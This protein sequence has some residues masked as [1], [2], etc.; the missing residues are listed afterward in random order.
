MNTLKVLSSIGFVVAATTP[1]VAQAQAQP[2]QAKTAP[3]VILILTDDQ[4]YADVGY[5]GNPNINTP[6]L[7]KLYGESLCFD[8]FHTGTTSAPTRSGLMTG[9]H[10]NRTGVWHTI[11]GRSIMDLDEYT[12]GQAFQ[13]SGYATAMYGKWHLGDNYP[14]RPADRGFEDVLWHK[15]GGVG[16]TPDYFGNTYFED[17][18]F[19]GAN[20]PE[21]QHGYCTDIFF[22]ET[23]RF[24]QESVAKEKPFFCYLALNAPHGPYNVDERW[25]AP[26]RSNPNVVNPAF[27][28][29]I[30]NIDFNIGKM[31]S[32]LERLDLDDNTII[33]FF[34]D[35]G[36]A[37]SAA[38]D[39]K[40]YATRGYNA[41][42]RGKKGQVY[43]GGHRQ[44]ML[45]HVPGKRHTKCQELATYADIMP[46]LIKA[47]GLTP[48]KTVDYDGVDI[49]SPE[50][51]AGRVFVVDT[52]RKQLMEENKM[53]CV[54]KDDWRLI[55]GKEL[56]NMS[57]DR[58]QRVNVAAKHP[59]IVTELKA[60]Y[61]KWWDHTSV[62][63]EIRQPIPL[64]T[65]I[66][67]ES[68][69]LNC[70]D[71]HDLQNRP[72]VWN[73]E[74]LQKGT[75]T[76]PGF[77]AVD[78]AKGGKYTL[79]AYRWAPESGLN[80]DAPAPK[81]RKIPNGESYPAGGAI[82]GM[83]SIKV[84]CG[85]KVIAEREN[86]PTDTPCVKFDN[87]KLPEGEQQLKVHIT[88]NNGKEFSAW[89]VKVTCN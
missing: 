26:Y 46:T 80:L 64:K 2:K 72:N 25:A 28:G 29:M 45:M 35:N 36:S 73:M 15:G 41:G 59:E 63:C 3:N 89:Y 61:K 39:K 87:L 18:Y 50:S 55:S 70:H 6:E 10:G 82:K 37:A 68:L 20:T 81:G 23:E 5:V 33:I 9:K 78:V 53:Y 38:L 69:I 84:L 27:Y 7:N 34:G 13:D 8:N 31:R 86:F 12:M 83:K 58:E 32:M 16:Q 21:K 57:N 76:A 19:R 52:Q 88:D 22:N 62:G 48:A 14:Y 85:D 49:L 40:G 51:R 43:E 65:N 77:W 4:G 74:I 24:I 30:S 56:F 44:A 47:C 60:E 66:K 71:L 42:L 17:T 67:G 79:E 1:M 54:I 11:G 75:Y